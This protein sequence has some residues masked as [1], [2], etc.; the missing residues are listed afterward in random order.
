M[1]IEIDN[2]ELNFNSKNILHGIYL[3]AET[4]KIT[5]ILGSNGTGKTSLLNI[6][7]G[8]LK[9]QHKLVRIDALPILKP[10]FSTGMVKLLPQQNLIP[11]QLKIQKAFK[12]YGLLWTGFIADFPDFERYEKAFIQELSGGERRVLEI[13]LSLKSPSSIVL[14]DEPFSH[15]SP[16]NIQKV[17]QLI[18]NSAEN[19]AIVITDHMFREV[20]DVADDLYLLQNGCSKK[21]KNLMELE[22]YRY[23]NPNTL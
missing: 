8:T 23:L 12:L 17:K 19:K 10:L 1:I 20:I 9:P 21:I 13:Y 5:G 4:G 3:R 2:I 11:Q 15:L 22:N 18:E 14:L 6:L 16:V 7:F